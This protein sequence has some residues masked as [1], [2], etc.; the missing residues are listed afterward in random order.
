MFC[1]LLYLL[2]HHWLY[3]CIQWHSKK[4]RRLLRDEQGSKRLNEEGLWKEEALWGREGG[5]EGGEKWYE[6]ERGKE[7]WEEEVVVVVVVGALQE[8]DV[9]YLGW[10]L[11]AVKP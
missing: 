4:N 7:E 11:R 1:P 3:F 9:M 10:L 8:D 6:M 5:G 2:L